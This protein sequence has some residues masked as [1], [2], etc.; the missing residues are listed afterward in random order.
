MPR[1]GR[2]WA[3]DHAFLRS[4]WRSANYTNPEVGVSDEQLTIVNFDNV[5]DPKAGKI[6][7]ELIVTQNELIPAEH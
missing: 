4:Q 2:C 6:D 1:G 7:H 3:R 5:S